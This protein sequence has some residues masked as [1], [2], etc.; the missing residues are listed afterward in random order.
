MAM[1]PAQR[2][3]LAGCLF[4]GT[5]GNVSA[6]NPS[7]TD[8]LAYRPKFTEVAITTPSADEAR[9]CE[10]QRIKGGYLLVNA[11]KQTLRKFVSNNGRSVDQWSYYK[12]GAEVYRELDS[13][14][15]GVPDQFRW[16]ATGGMKWGVDS[17]EDGKI[18]AWR[19]ISAE[20]AGHEAYLALANR[21]LARLKALLITE[22]EMQSLRL[23]AADVQRIQKNLQDL[24]A[25]FSKSA[26]QVPAGAV[27]IRVES[28]V[29]S[30]YP[31]DLSGTEQEL[32]KATNRTILFENPSAQD[33]KHQW[34]NTG[35]MIQ[36]GF[37]WRLTDVPSLEAPGMTGNNT[38]EAA[39]SPELKKHLDDLARLDEANRA[40][41]LGGPRGGKDPGAV[42]YNL[43]RVALIQKIL[44]LDK[45][46]NRETW[47]KQVCDNLSSAA[48][49][50]DDS[51]LA[52]LG[53]MVGQFAK[54]MPGSNLAAYARYREL[55]ARF[56]PQL[57]DRDVQKATKAQEEFQA[58]L[59]KYVQSY[60]QSE[61]APDALFQLALNSEFSGKQEEAKRWYKQ[62]YSNFPTHH[63]AGKAKGSE[64]RLGLV[65]QAFQL[66]GPQ[67]GSGVPFNA[68]Q[69]KG[70]VVV[71]Y[72]WTNAPVCIGDFARLKQV[73]AS[74]AGDVELVTV[75]LADSEADANSFLKSNPV[76]GTHLFQP[77]KDGVGMNSPLAE[78]Y[79]INGIPVL[80]L[81]GRDGRVLSTT[82]QVNDLEAAIKSAK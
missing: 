68:T 79:G 10:V 52:S 35:E 58:E 3:L 59:A 8:L 50:G 76:Q 40:K 34:L 18:D 69:L 26:G 71:V 22:A 80:F 9:T 4:L 56:T 49:A 2:G 5:L 15:N 66:T 33:N 39:T 53:Q 24:T 54:A 32:V 25:R 70:K 41:Y 48:V 30:V 57:V 37:A 17:N 23:P 63:Y 51:S 28:T 75:S 72:Y 29:P 31:A 46:E 36:V 64:T 11:K 62:L 45:A 6:Q 12:D 55:F 74:H 73:L 21:D 1:I 13:N 78:Q 42:D 20:E 43:K 82:G 19:M 81:I 65:G 67:L 7:A 27:F 47:Y 16:V 60:P 14:A 61:D 38:T 44:P 77:S